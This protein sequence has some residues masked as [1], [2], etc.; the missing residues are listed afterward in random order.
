MHTYAQTFTL[1]PLSVRSHNVSGLIG[2]SRRY[3]ITTSASGPRFNL[4][5]FLAKYLHNVGNRP[6]RSRAS[7]NL[8]SRLL[9]E[10]ARG[11]L[12]PRQTKAPIGGRI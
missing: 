2:T 5:I 11:H 10:M 1:L 6:V 9:W 3:Y 7:Y 4:A 12:A 8:S